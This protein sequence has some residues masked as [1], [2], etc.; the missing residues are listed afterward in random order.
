MVAQAQE[1]VFE[2]LS[3]PDP[4]APHDCSAQLRL[5]Q[6]AAQVRTGRPCPGQT[7]TGTCR[8]C[9][10][11]VFL[12]PGCLLAPGGLVRPPRPESLSRGQHQSEQGLGVQT[13]SRAR[14]GP[15]QG[16]PGPGWERRGLAG[17]LVESPGSPCVRPCHR[18]VAAEYERVHGAMA[19]PPVQDY[20]PF[21]WTTLVR[22]K[23]EHFRALAHYHAATALC[24]GSRECPPRAGWG[25]RRP[26]AGGSRPSLP[27]A[28]E[29]EPLALEQVFVGP[30]APSEPRRP[31]LPQEPE[32]RRKLGETAPCGV[33]GWWPSPPCHS[34]VAP[35]GHVWEEER[36]PLDAPA[37]GRRPE[38]R[39]RQVGAAPCSSCWTCSRDEPGARHL[40]CSCHIWAG[41]GGPRVTCLCRPRPVQARPT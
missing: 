32:E 36:P 3:L 19:R 26:G 20:V 10:S 2:G 16:R 12:G 41:A 34:E 38:Q 6:E 40:P 13:Q 7:C 30:P 22:V 8:G 17:R 33:G 21:A 24:D 37:W 35:A 15:G 4:A 31:V 27:P 25:G 9:V 5:A 23:A 18:Q 28:A 14:P 11:C 29:A 39:P 1:C